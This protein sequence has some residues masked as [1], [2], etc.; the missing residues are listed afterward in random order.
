MEARAVAQQHGPTAPSA[1]FDAV[2]LAGGRGSR[3]G[4]VSKGELEVGGRRLVDIAVVAAKDAGARRIIV[5]GPVAV[6]PPAV[7]VRE[8]RPFGGPAAG[9]ATALASVESPRLLLLA[10]DLPRAAE[11]VALLV[12]HLESPPAE[13]REPDDAPG[14]DGA[15]IVDAGGRVQWLAGL[16]R[17]EAVKRALE[18]IQGPGVHGLPLR[19]ILEHLELARVLDE[20]G[21]TA[22]IDTPEQ[23][24]AAHVLAASSSPI[25]P[26]D[27]PTTRKEPSAMTEKPKHLPPEALDE[28]LAEAKRLLELD[29]DLDIAAV[30][31]VAKDVAHNVARPAAPLTTFA[32]GVALG[33]RSSTA[34]SPEVFA[35]LAELVTARALAWDHTA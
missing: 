4:G 14:P 18:S 2:I 32:L 10:C 34:D 15:V 27:Q 6:D 16:Y 26:T 11:L 9:L 30:L 35:R 1:G 29:D 20:T 25:Q 17:A 13:L 21:A 7:V 23:L 33:R 28:W 31:D 24:E 12:G 5:V 8:A 3:L 19:R 22:D